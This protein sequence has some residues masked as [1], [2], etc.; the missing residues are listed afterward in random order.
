MKEFLGYSVD[1]VAVRT[2][3]CMLKL[4]LGITLPKQVEKQTLVMALHVHHD[5]WYISPTFSAK[6]DMKRIIIGIMLSL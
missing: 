1:E 4:S 5:F 2:S 6:H 3:L